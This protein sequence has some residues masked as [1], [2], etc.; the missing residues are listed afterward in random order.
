LGREKIMRR[1]SESSSVRRNMMVRASRPESPPRLK[2][3][4]R[5]PLDVEQGLTAHFVWST[6]R[7]WWMIAT[8]ISLVLAAISAA[9]VFWFFEPSF[10]AAAW[11]RM[12]ESTPF[13]AFETKNEGRSK[14]FFQTQ[15]ETIRSPLVL[16]PVIK[17]PEIARV[18]EI[19]HR[20]D[21]V[22]WLAKQIKV[23]SV[24]DSELFRI[25]Y[26]NPDPKAA[27]DIVNAVTESYFAVRDQNEAGRN[28]RVIDMLS[29]EKD[30]RS[31]ELARLRESVRGLT[32]T[33]SGIDPFSGKGDG[34]IAIARPL[35]DLEG[36]LISVQVDHAVLDAKIKALEEESRGASKSGEKKEKTSGVAM[37]S[38][39]SAYVDVLVDKAIDSSVEIQQQ[40]TMLAEKRANMQQLESTLRGGKESP[41]YVRASQE[42]V[43][44]ERALEEM[45]AAMRPKARREVELSILSK[46]GGSGAAVGVGRLGELGQLRSERE[47]CLAMEQTLKQR[48]E[49]QRKLT[50]QSSGDTVEL[51]FKSAE[52]A[53]AEKVFELISQ[54]VLQLQTERGAPSRVSLMQS[55]ESPSLPVESFPLRN[56]TLAILGS[57]ILPFAATVVWERIMGRVGDSHSLEQ[58][59]SLTVLGEITHLPVRKH[60]Q[61]SGSHSDIC[62][63]TR[64]FQESVESLRTS[65]SLSDSLAGIRVL[66]VTSAVKHEGK[67]S[68]AVQLAISFAQATGQ[69]VL[70]I[71]GDM[72]SPD[73][74]RVFEAPVEPGLTRVLAGQCSLEEAIVGS[75]R[76]NVDLLPAGKL[77]VSPHV[78]LGNG[79]WKS[80]MASIP[81]HYRYIVIDTPP[82]LAASEALVLA[83]AADASLVCAMCDVS[84]MEQVCETVDRLALAGCRPIGTVLN[85][86]PMHKYT[87]RYGYYA[88]IET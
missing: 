18:P 16:G 60:L 43:A 17:R 4:E 34:N 44:G 84:R 23:V 42:I 78:L 83:K 3:R 12:E 10:E 75:S 67:T 32:E 73:C 76:F 50:E 14:V 64:L 13:L 20:L 77:H 40:K 87:S 11:L 22:A 80:L 25:V 51:A 63:E 68:V 27:A 59:A 58:Q 15:I 62:H 81:S 56:I 9:L 54:R 26:C 8:P 70:L 21:K 2:G 57:L 31:K 45:R 30:K 39:E 82:V 28:Q 61:R 71:D 37:T 7:R 48:Y 33:A 5:S 74:H 53:R 65:L 47:A 49:E 85:G 66:A 55:A 29:E 86:V 46:R 1:H 35:I 72:R 19:A 41:F 38:D 52:L 6:L 24:G 88:D 36:R 69:P 79:A